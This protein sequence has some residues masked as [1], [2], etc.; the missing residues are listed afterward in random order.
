MFVY[1]RNVRISGIFQVDLKVPQLQRRFVF[2]PIPNFPICGAQF[3]T[4]S[5]DTRFFQLPKQIQSLKIRNSKP[6]AVVIAYETLSKIQGLFMRSRLHYQVDRMGQA[7]FFFSPCGHV[8]R[9]PSIAS[10]DFPFPFEPRFV[11]IFRMRDSVSEEEFV[12][13]LMREFITSCRASFI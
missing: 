1:F 12:K 3:F 8:S 7:V 11:W 9:E 2:I 10:D 6:V 5:D 13:R 4:S